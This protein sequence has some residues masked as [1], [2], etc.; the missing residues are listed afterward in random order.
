V[1][2]IGKEITTIQKKPS[3]SQQDNKINVQS[4]SQELSG[5]NAS[6]SH[7]QRSKREF[8]FKDSPGEILLKKEPQGNR[9]IKDYLG[10]H[11]PV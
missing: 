4:K 11:F 8:F 3:I 5:S 7:A 2:A 10:Y 9:P 6:L 1:G